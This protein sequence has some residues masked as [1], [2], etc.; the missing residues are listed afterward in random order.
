M[1]LV[2]EE[3]KDTA[4]KTNQLLYLWGTQLQEVVYS[5]P[6]ALLESDDGTGGVVAFENLVKN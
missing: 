4:E 2:P 6:G 3:I 5:I 1:Y